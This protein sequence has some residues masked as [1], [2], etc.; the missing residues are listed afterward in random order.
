MKGAILIKNISPIRGKSVT[1]YEMRFG[2]RPNVSSLR[3][4][5]SVGY[6]TIAE[7]VRSRQGVTK[8]DPRAIRCRLVGYTSL[9]K[10]YVGAGNLPEACDRLLRMVDD[11]HF[12]PDI[13]GS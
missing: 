6:V 13:W 7:E 11:R 10:Q 2:R 1:P 8:I 9:G 5:G 4:I 3:I 12:F